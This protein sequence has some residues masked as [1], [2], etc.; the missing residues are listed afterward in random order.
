MEI[1]F[2]RYK[3][4]K[5]HVQRNTEELET[6]ISFVDDNHYLSARKNRYPEQNTLPNFRALMCLDWV[7]RNSLIITQNL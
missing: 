4:V 1:V 3:T 5:L 7:I 6:E 2:C